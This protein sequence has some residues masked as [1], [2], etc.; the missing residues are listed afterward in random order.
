MRLD[1]T[2]FTIFDFETTGLYPYSGDKIC[3]IGAVRVDPKRNKIKK[4]HSLVDPERSVSY[5]AF[6]VNGITSDMLAGKPTIGHVLPDFIKFIEGSVLVA[7]NAGFDLGFLECAL[8]DEKNILNDYYIIDA[9]RLARRLFPAMGRYNLGHV[10]ESLGA[11]STGEHRALADAMMTWKV[12]EKE[13]NLLIA[14]GVK[15]VE[16]I[17]A[18]QSRKPASIKTVKDYKLKLIEDAIRTQKKLNIT[19]QSVW[20][21]RVTKRV[22]TPKEIQRGYDKSYV[23]AH[24]HLKNDERNFRLDCILE[25][26]PYK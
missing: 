9:L 4:F 1:K 16:E 3:E 20:N 8:G 19:Y 26:K 11:S 12:F 17:A 13:L 25:A 23:I 7:Y 22:I 6:Y 21:N 18:A 24:C 2:S 15:S 14:E 5:G 10:S